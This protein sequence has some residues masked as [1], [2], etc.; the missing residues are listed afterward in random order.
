MARISAGS[1]DLNK[2]LHGGYETDIVSVI[3]GSSGT[4]KTNLCL[5]AAVSQAKKGNKVIY[6]DTEGGFSVERIKQLSPE[7]PEKVLKNI[8]LLKPTNFQEQKES[9]KTLLYYLKNEI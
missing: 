3:Y 5:L 7:A 8:L 9:F 4:G 2:F 1:Y 6:I